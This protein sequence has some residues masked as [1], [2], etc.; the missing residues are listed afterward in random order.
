MFRLSATLV[1]SLMVAACA[2]RPVHAPGAQAPAPILHLSP[3]SLGHGLALQQQLEFRFGS[4]RQTV[5]ALL[6]ADASEVRLALQAMGQNALRLR[7]DGMHL[8]ETRASWL[9]AAL[10]SERVLSDLQLVYWPAA[11]IRRVLPAGWEVRDDA[12]SRQLLQ[13]GDVVV[14]VRFP[15]TGRVELTQRREG[16]RLIIVSAAP[17]GQAQ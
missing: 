3:A 17:E 6:E 2:S 8:Q 11:E 9:P 4:H 7:W 14:D 13:A 5:D 12:G 15:A 1:L 16:Y 10:Q